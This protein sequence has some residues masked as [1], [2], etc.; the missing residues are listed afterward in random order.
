[1]E[2]ITN[3]EE[4]ELERVEMVDPLV[5]AD[6]YIPYK[7]GIIFK[8]KIYVGQHT[9]AAI[10]ITLKKKNIIKNLRKV[11]EDIEVE[12]PTNEV[13]EECKEEGAP[14]AEPE[15][16]ETEE[17]N[18]LSKNFKVEIF[19]NDELLATYNGNGHLNI[20]HFNFRSNTGL[21]DKP[22]EKPENNEEAPPAEGENPVDVDPNQEYTHH[23]VIQATFD[24][25]DWPN[26]I[27]K[28]EETKD[29]TWELRIF[30]SDTV[31]IVKD[32]DKE[33]REQALK[34]SWETAE[35]G[36]AEKSKKSRMRYIAELK[37]EK[38]EELT[39]EE[40][41]ILSDKRVRG[42]ANLQ[43]NVTDPK[44]GKGKV[45]KKGAASLDEDQKEEETPEVFPSSTDYT[46]LH[47]REFIHHF[48]SERLIHVK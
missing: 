20:S 3:R 10:N 36:R 17:I 32:T 18:E 48:E 25:N 41:E 11:K 47:F 8:E 9:S 1:M 27:S 37:K 12:A 24:K 15:Y 2:M 23:Y 38:G 43:E 46:N 6:E 31:A 40:Q 5:Y 21:E 29:V 34:D 26:A 7:Y 44:G 35:P 33:D 28:N 13:K 42:A 39:E 30:S 16:E 45:D 19:D 14:D 22:G 4:L